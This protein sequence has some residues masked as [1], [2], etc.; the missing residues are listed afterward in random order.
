MAVC[1]V[2]VLSVLE[3]T[4]VSKRGAIGSYTLYLFLLVVSTVSRNLVLD[5]PESIQSAPSAGCSVLDIA[6]RSGF[7]KIF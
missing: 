5:A 4:V 1:C 3:F 6:V 7:K 2:G